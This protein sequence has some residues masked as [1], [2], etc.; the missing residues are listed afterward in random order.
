ME[1][2]LEFRDFDLIKNYKFDDEKVSTVT[3]RE[4]VCFNNKDNFIPS[5]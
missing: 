4:Q 2:I 3:S 1:E 5:T